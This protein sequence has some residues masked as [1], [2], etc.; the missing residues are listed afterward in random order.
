MDR[1]GQHHNNADRIVRCKDDLFRNCNSGNILLLFRV[2]RCDMKATFLDRKNGG[3][4]E[5]DDLTGLMNG[6][7]WYWLEFAS[8]EQSK[9]PTSEYVLMD[10]EA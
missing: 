8:G 6:T 5:K 2:R 7:K 9:L 1:L 3:Y 4:I 10:V